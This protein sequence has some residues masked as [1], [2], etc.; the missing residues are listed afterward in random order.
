MEEK[1]P[2]NHHELEVPLK[3]LNQ[4]KDTATKCLQNSLWN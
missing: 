3:V 4:Q 2:I 1:K